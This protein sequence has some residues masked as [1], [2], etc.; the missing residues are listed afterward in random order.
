ML[1]GL[2]GTLCFLIRRF[3]LEIPL[4]R[5]VCVVDQH[6]VRVVL[7]AFRL[8]FHGA[9]ILLDEFSENK[10]QKLGHERDPSK[11]IPGGDHVDTTLIT[12]DRGN[13][14]EAGKPVFAG[15]DGFRTNVGQNEIDGRC[16]GIGVSIKP[17]KFIG[18]GV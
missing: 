3:Q 2:A 9:A 17:Q 15:S 16:D 18:R 14:R 12:R 7:Q 1:H 10:F 13:C 8:K 5:T 6:K 4:G 11:K